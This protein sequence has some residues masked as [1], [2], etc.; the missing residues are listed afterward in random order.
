M[1]KQEI[2]ECVRFNNDLSV[3]GYKEITHPKNPGKTYTPVHA[4]FMHTD[5]GEWVDAVT[6]CD[7]QTGVMYCRRA[8]DFAKFSEVE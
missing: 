7:E 6:Y 5:T 3:P 8:D 1:K 4:V 2:L